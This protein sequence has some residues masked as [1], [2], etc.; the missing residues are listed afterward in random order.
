MMG[1]NFYQSFVSYKLQYCFLIFFYYK[2]NKKV[3]SKLNYVFQ[4]SNLAD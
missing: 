3:E 1:A 2:N 4:T